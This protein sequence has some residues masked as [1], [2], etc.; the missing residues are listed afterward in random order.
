MERERES[1]REIERDRERERVC[2]TGRERERERESVTERE[3]RGGSTSGR[4][5]IKRVCSTPS[6]FISNSELAPA[7]V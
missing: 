2:V 7:G 1:G 4:R 3:R 6:N 5:G